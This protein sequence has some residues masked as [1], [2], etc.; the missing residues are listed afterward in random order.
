MEI[1]EQGKSKMKKVLLFS[2]IILELV[3][4]LASCGNR[5]GVI[6]SDD[7]KIVIGV[8]RAG[9]KK[10]HIDVPEGATAIGKSAFEACRNLKSIT[11]PY[12]ITKIEEK[13]FAYCTSLEDITLPQSVMAIGT[14][15]FYTCTSLTALDIPQGVTEIG[16]FAFNNCVTLQS[17][18]IPEGVTTIEF[19]TFSSCLSLKDVEI[20][21]GVKK[22]GV[23]AFWKCESL[24][25]IFIPQSVTE[26][27]EDA[28]YGCSALERIE[29]GGTEANW[30]NMKIAWDSPQENIV[31]VGDSEML[32]KFFKS[33]SSKN[34]VVTGNDGTQ[35]N[36]GGNR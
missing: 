23:G 34:I 27:G 28:F 24:E 6:L 22:I 9:K 13:A 3:L 29:Y 2:A 5:N 15:A 31:I 11:I 4:L 26:I 19:D 25:R 16:K 36:T 7:G 35:W 18:R 8:T 12:G 10:C 17:I 32:E 14:G 1:K 21:Q 20:L 30:Q 33:E